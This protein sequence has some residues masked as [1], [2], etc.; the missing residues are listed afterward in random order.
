[1]IVWAPA[2]PATPI[3]ASVSKECLIILSS[4]GNDQTGNASFCTAVAGR[5]YNSGPCAPP[6]RHKLIPTVGGK[7]HSRRADANRSVGKFPGPVLRALLCRPGDRRF[8]RRP[9]RGGAPA[10]AQPTRRG[11]GT[12]G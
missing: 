11:T 1:M 3:S 9:R 10:L 2:V 8:P 6:L 12:A 4:C 7:R 5:K